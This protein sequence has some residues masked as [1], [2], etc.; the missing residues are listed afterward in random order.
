MQMFCQ[1]STREKERDKGVYK[2]ICEEVI[3][4]LYHEIETDMEKSYNMYAQGLYCA[5]YFRSDFNQ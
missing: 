3:L 4:M 5:Q 2:K 1:A